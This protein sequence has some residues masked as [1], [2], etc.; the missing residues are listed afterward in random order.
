[1][2]W[3]A[4]LPVLVT[5]MVVAANVQSAPSLSRHPRPITMPFDC[6]DNR[7]VVEVTIQKSG[8]FH[9][10]LDTG[11]VAAISE[12]TAKKLGVASAAILKQAGAGES[13]VRS[14]AA[15]LS[16]LRLGPIELRDL[17]VQVLPMDDFRQVFGTKPVDGIVG[18]PIFEAMVVKLDF[19]HHVITFEPP[20]QLAYAGKGSV[21][22]F[23]LPNQIP[24][25]DANLDGISGAFGVDTGARSA[26]LLYGPFVKRNH[27]QRK[28]GAHLEGVTGWGIGGPV[29][30]LL[31]RAQTLRFGDLVV[32]EP[33]IRLSTQQ[34]GL[35]TSSSLAGL[36]GPDVL[37]QFDVT[38]DYSRHQII[39]EKNKN[40]GRHDSYDRAG[41]WM[42]QDGDAFTAMDVISGGPAD[43]AGLRRGDRILAIDGS[44]TAGLVLPEI[45]ERLR[46]QSVGTTVKLTV[47]AG[48]RR[49]EIAITLRDLV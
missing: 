18:L 23:D 26:L 17:S 40:S 44:K 39:F 36:I 8:P 12:S 34:A 21:V 30:S 4:L 3:T 41:V 33:A 27:L 2:L 22:R 42:G 15:T 20:A 28:Y 24:V 43:Q 37:A 49:K 19:V 7:V 31:A 35:T 6:V 11:A 10:L 14:G 32:T 46:R 9:F 16:S 13:R 48:G 25:I 38:F 29:R 5:G 47:E 45:R 1:M